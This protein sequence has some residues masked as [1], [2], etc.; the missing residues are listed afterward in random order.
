MAVRKGG[1]FLAAYMR[2]Q[3][4]GR[5][6]FW[7]NGAILAAVA[8]V[9]LLGIGIGVSVLYTVPPFLIALIGGGVY[10]FFV[11]MYFA[12]FYRFSAAD[13]VELGEDTAEAL[14]SVMYSVETPAV[15]CK[16][17]GRILWCNDAFVG[18]VGK[19]GILKGELIERVAGVR[20]GDMHLAEES[21]ERDTILLGDKLYE[22]EMHMAGTS[23]EERFIIFR[24]ST[25]LLSLKRISHEQQTVV[26]YITVDN[27]EEILQFVQERF[28]RSAN[29][30]EEL[31]RKWVEGM[32]GIFRSYEK[33]KYLALFSAEAAEKM[34]EDRFSILDEIRSI[35]V[36]DG[37]SITVSAGI[38]NVSGTLAEREMVAESAL[39][40][41]LQR[42][43]DQVV[44]RTDK[45]TD[46]YGGKTKSIYKRASVRA[47]VIAGQIASLIGRADNVLIM[48][49]RFGDFDSIA[50]AVGM[51]RFAMHCGAKVNVVVNF[52]DQNIRASVERMQELPEFRDV[53]IDGPGGLDRIRP[54]TLLIVVDVNNFEHV[55][56][57][58]IL[59]NVSNIVVVDHHRK[60]G[61]TPVKP[62]VTYIE[63]SAS[64]ASELVAEMLEQ[65]LSG[66]SLT[67][68]EA[69]LLLSGILLDTQQFT[70]NTGTRTFAAAL[71]LRG[72]GADPSETNEFFKS[73]M[74]DVVKEAKFHSHVHIYRENIAITVCAEDADA[75]YRVVA[76]KA[77][78]KL[79]QVKDVEASFALV[80]IDGKVHISARS[81]GKINVQL[82]LEKL[83][84][85]GHFDVAGAQVESSSSHAVVERLKEAIDTYFREEYDKKDVEKK[86]ET[87][88]DED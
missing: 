41:A 23:H 18:V 39:D 26:A 65:V 66:K 9:L 30:V 75:S 67:K 57:P 40:L 3:K 49:H 34:A 1:R 17:N 29:D 80:K 47:R 58:A 69:E 16:K 42:G 11:G 84:G 2:N 76:A 15:L 72:E 83:N 28:R 87:E 86:D 7:R 55:E 56:S 52:S 62:L 4:N 43:G 64:S 14:T 36:G 24:D 32:N 74:D 13:P 22:A 63:P 78:N 45:G 10:L 71:Y 59:R 77:A 20:L 12:I 21:R 54:D 79:L 19:R 25:E 50:S 48:G 35:R 82:I 33:N 44:Y 81:A 5:Q 46:F 37:I 6:L 27:I 51:A 8:S 85:G 73:E 68:E 70:R 61:D 31:L 88:E 60:T 53:F 38:A